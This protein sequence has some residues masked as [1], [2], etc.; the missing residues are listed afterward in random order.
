ML[1]FILTF[2][3]NL[4]LDIDECIAYEN[5]CG[6]NAICR[7]ADPG[8]TCDCPPG[9]SANPSPKVACDQVNIL[10]I[11]K[12]KNHLVLFAKIF[13]NFRRTLQHCVN[14]ILTALMMQSVSKDNVSAKMASRHLVL[15]AK[16]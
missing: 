12:S 16:M 1:Q 3:L 11:M 4:N 2:V 6:S 9:Y 7:N 10:I 5:P 13:V 8:Y 14:R 15:I